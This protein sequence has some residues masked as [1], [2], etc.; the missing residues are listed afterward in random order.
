MVK[1]ISLGNCH[2]WSV[3]SSLPSAFILHSFSRKRGYLLGKIK[4]P[5]DTILLEE[6]EKANS[7]LKD[8]KRPLPY[9][10]EELALER[11]LLLN[12][13]GRRLQS[14]CKSK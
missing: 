3:Y 12:S 11:S 9:I 1:D 4:N 5:T 8:V 10:S 7:Y 13:F 2:V 6:F 14:E